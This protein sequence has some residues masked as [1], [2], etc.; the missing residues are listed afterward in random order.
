MMASVGV[1]SSTTNW[2]RE[3]CDSKIERMGMCVCVAR[4]VTILLVADGIH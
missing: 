4:D 2:M 1:I 3:Y